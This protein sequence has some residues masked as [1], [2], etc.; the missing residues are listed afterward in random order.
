MDTHFTGQPPP[1]AHTTLSEDER[2]ARRMVRTWGCGSIDVDDITQEVMIALEAGRAAFQVPPGRTRTDAWRSFVWGVVARQVA[3]YRRARARRQQ[4]EQGAAEQAQ[5]IT[6]GMEETMIAE[7]PR[8]ALRR[9]VA[10]LAP[11]HH[12][13]MELVLS[14]LSISEVATRLN[15]PS[16]T[17]WTRFRYAREAIR[18]ELRAWLAFPAPR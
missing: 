16:G 10:A 12:A 11:H 5:A 4:G 8:L 6:P 2:T 17:A 1:S 3:S 9:A 18:A 7:S 13:V 15:I 14:G